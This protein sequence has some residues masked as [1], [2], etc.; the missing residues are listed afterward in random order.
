MLGPEVSGRAVGHF[1]PVIDVKASLVSAV[2]D[3]DV[4]PALPGAGELPGAVTPHHKLL[5]GA[6][7]QKG[8]EGLAGGLRLF[9]R[10]EQLL[11]VALVAL[12]VLES[13]L[14]H[15][16]VSQLQPASI[17]GLDVVRDRRSVENIGFVE[18]R[19]VESLERMS[20]FFDFE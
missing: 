14:Q 16:V 18:R 2:G 12:S 15:I 3:R 8:R 1:E 20:H 17:V 11:H 9:C 7:V 19:E 13:V 5:P 10:L 6:R 4:P